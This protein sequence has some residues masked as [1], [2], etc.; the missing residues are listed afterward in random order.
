MSARARSHCPWIRSVEAISHRASAR[1]SVHT[2]IQSGSAPRSKRRHSPR[3]YPFSRHTTQRLALLRPTQTYLAATIDHPE[4]H[5]GTNPRRR[6]P[7][8]G[9]THASLDE[10]KSSRYLWDCRNPSGVV[11][12]RECYPRTCSPWGGAAG[13]GESFSL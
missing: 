3:I 2:N 13:R 7:G 1:S 9:L 12:R 11:G 10:K 5:H 6:D 4:Q 8:A